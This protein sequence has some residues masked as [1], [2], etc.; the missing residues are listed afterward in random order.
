TESLAVKGIKPLDVLKESDSVSRDD[1]ERFDNDM[2]LM[3][4]ELSAM[5]A[6]IVT[7]LGG[8]AEH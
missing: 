2:L 8:E 7:S 5:L 3:T 1:N 6:D 4:G